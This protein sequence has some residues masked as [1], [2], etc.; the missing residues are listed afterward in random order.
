MREDLSCAA[1]GN[2]AVQKPP[3]Q[4]NNSCG[5]ALHDPVSRASGNRICQPLF[6]RIHRTVLTNM[7]QTP[8]WVELEH[9]L[10][11]HKR[12]GTCECVVERQVLAR[13]VAHGDGHIGVVWARRLLRA[14]PIVVPPIVPGIHLRIA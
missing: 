12:E 6:K 13:I 14:E 4:M 10:N 3:E 1:C 2:T 9:F 11:S 7:S 5:Y 8:N